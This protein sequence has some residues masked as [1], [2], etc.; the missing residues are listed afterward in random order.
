M[1]VLL[2]EEFRAVEG[3]IPNKSVEP[4]SKCRSFSCRGRKVFHRQRDR[5]PFPPGGPRDFFCP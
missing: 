1:T 3:D 2:L 4:S 5:E